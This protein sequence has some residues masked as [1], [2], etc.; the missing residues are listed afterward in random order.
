MSVIS[1]EANDFIILSCAVPLITWGFAEMFPFSV[2]WWTLLSN[3]FYAPHWNL[4]NPGLWNS[5]LPWQSDCAD[6]VFYSNRHRLEIEDTLFRWSCTVS[7]KRLLWRDYLFNSSSGHYF[8]LWNNHQQNSKI[9]T[10]DPLWLFLLVFS[11]GGSLMKDIV[12]RKC[13]ES[14]H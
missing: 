11:V 5:V 9:L 4:Q 14:S 1:F 13:L 12:W 7:I 3:F 8:R 10:I 6:L 2:Y